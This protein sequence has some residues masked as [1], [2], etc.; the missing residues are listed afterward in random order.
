MSLKKLFTRYREIILYVFFGGCTTLVNL[1]VYWAATR[2]LSLS[3]SPAT[4]LAWALSVLFAYVTNRIWVFKSAV[5]TF[6]GILT[7]AGRFF[8][9]RAATGGMDIGMMYLFVTVLELP[10]MPVKI[11]SNILVIL[12]NY[13]FSKLLIFRRKERK[14]K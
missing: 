9:A 1:L 13:V 3:V 11:A 4:V 2:L 6:L 14:A 12:L 10:D 8:L 5:R 7:E